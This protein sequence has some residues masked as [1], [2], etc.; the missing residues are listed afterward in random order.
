MY[1]KD[2]AS[3]D[4]EG[5][6]D[7]FVNRYM[8]ESEEYKDVNYKFLK[9]LVG[10]FSND[11]IDFEDIISKNLSSG[12]TTH[13]ISPINKSVLKTAI[14]ETIFE[15]TDAPVI[16]NEYVEIAKLFSDDKSAKFI[17]AILD[18]ISKQVDRKCKTKT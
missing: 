8:K 1:Q 12:K 15:K 13:G 5:V 18:K 17:N 7:N 2:V 10:Y 16:I 4:I 11:E 14:L 6:Y 9:R 3:L